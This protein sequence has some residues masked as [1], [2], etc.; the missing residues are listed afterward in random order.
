M[1]E[2]KRTPLYSF[3]HQRQAHWGEFAGWEV[4][5]F[6]TSILEEAKQTRQSAGLWDVSHMGRFV[7]SGPG[8]LRDLEYLTPNNVERLGVHRGHYTLLL[9]ESAGILDDCILFRWEEEKYYLVVNAGNTDKDYQWIQNHLHQASLQNI[10]EETCL[11]ALQGPWAASYLNRLLAEPVDSL[12]PFAGRWDR[13]AGQPIYLTRT[14]YTGEDGF[15]IMVAREGGEKV[16][17]LLIEAGGKDLALCGLGARDVLR[18]EAGYPLYDHE[19]NENHHP[20]EA[21]LGF[22][23]KK[24]QG[25]IGAE[26][27]QRIREQGFHQKLVGLRLAGRSI[28]RQGETVYCQG[29]EVGR[30]TSGT[31]SP[32]LSASIALAYLRMDATKEGTEVIVESPRRQEKA[33]VVPLPFFD[34]PRARRRR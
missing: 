26:A 27:L 8:A 31:F 14:G 18:I 30:I 15:E 17:N 24:T 29:E 25:F 21:G 28:A 32:C 13:L 33:V 16:W 2:L 34:M 12:Q 19:I 5:I 23:I 11:L 4:P 20:L 10:T 7:V 1:P 3:H 9:N 22:V 6:F